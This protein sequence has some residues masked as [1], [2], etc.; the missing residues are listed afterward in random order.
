MER[1]HAQTAQGL[2]KA[3]LRLPKFLLLKQMCGGVMVLA[4]YLVCI[5]LRS[6]GLYISTM[7][8]RTTGTRYIN[9]LYHPSHIII[10]STTITALPTF[11]MSDLKASVV[12][13]VVTTHI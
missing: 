10:Q 11:V 8:D 12:S 6:T 4:G 7:G 13:Y 5:P 1:G 2:R 9:T 3:D